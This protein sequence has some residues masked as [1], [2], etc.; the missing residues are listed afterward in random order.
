M[1]YVAID[2]RNAVLHRNPTLLN[3]IMAHSRRYVV[4]PLAFGFLGPWVQELCA[5]A[6][7]VQHEDR[8]QE[9]TD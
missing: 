6:E 5:K 9:K 7:G 4:P 1:Y 8:N 3:V 2:E